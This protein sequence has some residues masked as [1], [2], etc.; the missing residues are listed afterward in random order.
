MSPAQTLQKLVHQPPDGVGIGFLLTDGTA[1][2]QGNAESD[3][4][5]LTPDNTGSYVNGTWTKVGSLQS[6]YVPDAFASAVLADGR[7]VIV[8]G[9]YNNGNFDLTNQSAIFSPITN[10]WSVLQPPASWPFIGD[11]PSS[12]LPN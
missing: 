1:L 9:E 4:W 5:K 6:G 8:G 12:V 3:W 10:T 11:S 7:V 2:F